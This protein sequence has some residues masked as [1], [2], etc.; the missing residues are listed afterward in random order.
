MRKLGE[1]LHQAGYRVVYL[2]GLSPDAIAV[3][4]GTLVA[5]LVLRERKRDRRSIKGMSPTK[6]MQVKRQRYS[7]FDNVIFA[8]TDAGSSGFRGFC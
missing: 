2:N 5:V 8:L 4:H 7:M 6:T 3:K 1:R